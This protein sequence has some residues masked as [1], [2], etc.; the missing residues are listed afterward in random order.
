MAPLFL[1]RPILQRRDCQAARI[2]RLAREACE[3]ERP[4]FVLP[5]VNERRP[6]F[7]TGH[8]LLPRRGSGGDAGARPI[9]ETGIAKQLTSPLSSNTFWH[10][11]SPVHGIR[12][13]AFVIPCLTKTR[14]PFWFQ[15][16]CA[17]FGACG[18]F[19]HRVRTV[20]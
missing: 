14:S 5:G 7:R 10:E 17:F 4:T 12:F 2:G 13:F 9:V 6:C 16:R 18:T 8:G 11:N 20:T 3:S 1:K 15:R 19:V